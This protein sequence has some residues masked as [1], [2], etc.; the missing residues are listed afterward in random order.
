MFFDQLTDVSRGPAQ[1]F[2]DQIHPE[3]NWH[4]IADVIG[5]EQQYKERHLEETQEEV[6][7][8]QPPTEKSFFDHTPEKP[9]IEE[10]VPQLVPIESVESPRQEDEELTYEIPVEQESLSHHIPAM[11]PAQSA[12]QARARM[13]EGLSRYKG[14]EEPIKG[15]IQKEEQDHSKFGEAEPL[16]KPQ[17]KNPPIFFDEPV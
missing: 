4:S 7:L 13:H 11:P 16:Q 10:E 1:E 14:K 3:H 6:P 8:Y 15:N 9:V 5:Y 17:E 2:D 12:S